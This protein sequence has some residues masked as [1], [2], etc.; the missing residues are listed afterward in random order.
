MKDRR[1]CESPSENRR[2]YRPGR[3]I[4]TELGDT[5]AQPVVLHYKEIAHEFKY[6][7]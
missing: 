2:P 1:T 4:S 7:P 6:N 3:R 5:D